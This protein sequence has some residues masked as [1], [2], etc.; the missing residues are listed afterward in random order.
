MRLKEKTAVILVCAVLRDNLD[1]RPKI[2][3]VFG[4]VIV[5]NNFHFFDGV[6]I[7]SNNG[8]ATPGH[9]GHAHAVDGVVVLTVARTARHNLPAVLCLKNAVSAAG[10]ADGGSRQI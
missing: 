6:F 8:G 4:I 5:G 3:A 1:L 2:T 9:A 10:A 7:R